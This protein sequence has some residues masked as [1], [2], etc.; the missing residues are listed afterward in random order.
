MSI[1]IG[2]VAPWVPSICEDGST[3]E[4]SE[5]RGQNIILYFYPKDDTPGCT[6]E[7]QDFTK[8]LPEFEKLKTII[9]GVSKDSKSSHC[10][11][12]DKYNIGFN[13]IADE[14]KKLCKTYG[15]LKEKSMFG[16]KYMGIQ[17]ST[18]LI[19]SNGNIAK[20]WRNV[21]VKG[22]VEEVINLIKTI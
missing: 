12:I 19:D 3:I 17:R 18:F 15:V 11:F 1:E 7:A 10:K 14:E 2:N 22:H 20:I 16:K 5:L 13:L 9:L 6:I 8:H 21:K 4:L